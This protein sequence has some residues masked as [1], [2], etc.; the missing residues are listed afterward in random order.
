MLSDAG[1]PQENLFIYAGGIAEW[2]TNWYG[3]MT[4]CT[5]I[6]S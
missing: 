2:T 3:N 4:C 5:I 1:V 6:S